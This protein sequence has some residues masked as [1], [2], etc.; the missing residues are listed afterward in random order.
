MIVYIVI[1]S[2]DLDY[3][4]IEGVY[5]NEFRATQVTTDFNEKYKD[6]GYSCSYSS[7]TVIER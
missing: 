4:H 6:D 1:S 7:Y 5:M 2:D 3:S